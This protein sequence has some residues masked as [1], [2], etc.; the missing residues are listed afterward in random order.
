MKGYDASMMLFLNN[1]AINMNT[2]SVIEKSD[3]YL[4]EPNDPKYS[5]NF[6]G[7]TG[8]T[9][10]TLYYH[11]EYDRNKDYDDFIETVKM[12]K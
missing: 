6:I 3:S 1:M 9:V 5:I 7:P 10:M 11:S 8:K 4:I 2:I 12:N